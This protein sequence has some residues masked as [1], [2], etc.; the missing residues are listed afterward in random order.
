MIPLLI[1]IIFVLLIIICNQRITL[2]VLMEMEKEQSKLVKD[3]E[4]K[5]KNPHV[6][7]LENKE[8]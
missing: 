3:I 4:E 6:T 1:I 7:V 2:S 8:S 5:V